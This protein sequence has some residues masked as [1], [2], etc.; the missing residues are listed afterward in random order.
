MKIIIKS[1]ILRRRKFTINDNNQLLIQKISKE[2]GLSEEYV[3]R[4]T[5]EGRKLQPSK[6][7]RKI[8]NL[9]KE[10][11]ELNRR[12]FILEGEWS[13][14]RYKAHT[15]AKDNKTLALVLTGLLSQNRTLRRQLGLKKEYDELRKLVDYYIFE[16]HGSRL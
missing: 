13:A 11:D 4:M 15:L 12:M 3:V 5:I 14:L 1:G 7:A 2:Y 16:V 8:E 9:R 10:I 6:N